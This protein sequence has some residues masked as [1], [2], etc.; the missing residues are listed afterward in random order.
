MS[1]RRRGK[2]KVLALMDKLLVPPDD[3]AAFPASPGMASDTAVLLDWVTTF[4]PARAAVTATTDVARTALI[5]Q[6]LISNVNPAQSTLDKK[7][8]A[9]PIQALSPG[10]ESKIPCHP[11]I[12]IPAR[13]SVAPAKC[14]RVRTSPRTTPA[15]TV[16][17]IV[18]VEGAITAPCAK[19]ANA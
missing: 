10:A 3:P 5:C 16:L 6:C 11:I 8:K 14:E 1:T 17:K 19:G 7:N 2:L 13:T 12:V 18:T 15:A 4:V 9:S